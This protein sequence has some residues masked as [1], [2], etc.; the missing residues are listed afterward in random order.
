MAHEKAKLDRVQP[1]ERSDC[2]HNDV[3]AGLLLRSVNILMSRQFQ[4]NR[5]AHIFLSRFEVCTHR[6]PY[7]ICHNFRPVMISLY[8]Y[9]Y[10]RPP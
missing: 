5:C 6:E 9:S 1:I 10:R 7:P 8:E 3:L 4:E 2:L